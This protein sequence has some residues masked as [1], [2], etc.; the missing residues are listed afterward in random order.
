MTDLR[1][2]PVDSCMHEI[3]FAVCTPCHSAYP[4]CMRLETGLPSRAC[5]CCTSPRQHRIGIHS[6]RDH[7]R[8]GTGSQLETDRRKQAKPSSREKKKATPQ[9]C[10]KAHQKIGTVHCLKRSLSGVVQSAPPPAQRSCISSPSVASTRC[11]I[12]QNCPNCVPE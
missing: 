2:V 4:N 12:A 11:S 6:P 1:P 10:D 7:A 3:Y 5:R 9:L 8:R